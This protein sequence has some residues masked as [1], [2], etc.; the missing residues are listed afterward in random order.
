MFEDYF[1]NQQS[2][3]THQKHIENILKLVPEE[4]RQ[5]ALEN[6]SG[7]NTSSVER[8]ASLEKTIAAHV[9]NVRSTVLLS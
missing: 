3:L 8:W 7:S 2:L 1:V 4:I 6:W 9:A 5:V